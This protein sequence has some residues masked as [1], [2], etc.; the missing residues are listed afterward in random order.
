MNPQEIIA[1]IQAGICGAQVTCDGDGSHFDAT[2]IS[3]T[4][5]GKNTLT[6]QRLVFE[7]LGD[8]ITSGRLHNLNLRTLTRAEAGQT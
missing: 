8:S 7:A 3:D 5:D 6:R 1:M 2:V 4:F